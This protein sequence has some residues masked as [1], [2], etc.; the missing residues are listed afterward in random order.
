METSPGARLALL[1]LGGFGA[2]VEEVVR[3]L[4]DRGHPGV[5]AT[6][7]FAL[8][9]VDE[10]FDS[11]S[12]LGRRLGVSKQAAAKTIGALERLGYLERESVREDARRTRLRVT[13]R[14]HEMIAIGAARFDAIRARWAAVLGADRLA[15]VE[16]ALVLAVGREPRALPPRGM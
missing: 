15:T 7:E 2:M 10:G 8:A 3:D 4:A 14:G 6:H 1:L 9:A 16:D 5:T 13:E 11:A 12:A